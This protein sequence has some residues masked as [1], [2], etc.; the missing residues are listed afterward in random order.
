MTSR[1]LVLITGAAGGVGSALWPRLL[2]AYDVRLF[3]RAEPAGVP[4]AVST[5]RGDITDRAA[6]AAAVDGVSAVVH[7][8]GN[9]FASATW[10]EL[11]DP[12]LIGVYRVL[13]AAAAAG[14]GRVVLA[15]SCHAAGMY[16]VER[17]SGV[18]PAWLPRPCCPYGVSKVYA[19]T[20]GRWFA[21]HTDLSVI[22]LRLG[23][24]TERPVSAVGVPFW[25]SFD[26]LAR[27]V[28]G[29]LR[30]EVNYGV[31]Y[32]GSA[33]ARERWNLQPGER[34][35]GYVAHD[36]SAEH[37]DEIDL[38]VPIPACYTGSV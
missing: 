26:D 13:E 19:E 11:V 22:A 20:A 29:A 25:L 36:D 28:A 18:D 34:D 33:N 8:A 35:L 3:D 30:T 14:V 37:L 16:D 17:A 2:D 15:S 27:L 38:S 4:A 31:Y 10:D 12:N 23:A 5:I 6:L 32:G 9:R 21:E 7:L 24:V 1:P